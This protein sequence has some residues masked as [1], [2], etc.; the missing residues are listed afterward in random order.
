MADNVKS[1]ELGNEVRN[2]QEAFNLLVSQAPA[3]I[4]LIRVGAPAR[5][6]KEEWT[7]YSLAPQ[8]TTIASFDGGT[9]TGTGIN[10]ASTTGM[11]VGQLLRFESS[12]GADRGEIVKIASV[13]SSTDL[14]VVRQYGSYPGSAVT[15]AVGDSVINVSKP[16]NEATSA[17]ATDNTEPSVNYNYT[18]I[19]ERTATLSRTA[20]QTAQ[21]GV[22]NEL[23]FQI[24]T[25]MKELMFEFNSSLIYGERVQR[26]ASQN[27]TFGGILAMI[28]GGNTDT[29]G[30][31]ISKTILNNLFEACFS[32]GN[33][34]NNYAILCAPNQARKIS[35]F[36]TSGSNPIVSVQQDAKTT[37]GYVQTFVSDLPAAN[38]FMG[39][40]VVEP[41]FPKDKIA[42][43]DLNNIEIAYLQPFGISD[44]TLPGYDGTMQRVLGE[45]TVRVMNGTKAHGIA[46]GLTI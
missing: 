31:A 25:K 21:Y 23:S 1:Y 37:G 41:S 36:N 18:Q 35:A 38:G 8:S 45:A 6:T 30:G 3:L 14:T 11:E 17:S 27:G 7:E 34:S 42:L 39:K 2:V 29:T 15:L 28:R 24:Q 10:V 12:A 46:T 26:S 43:I 9:A 40:I 44:A 16:K 33:V 32:D 19:F 20:I 13:D 4:S 22:A 5:A